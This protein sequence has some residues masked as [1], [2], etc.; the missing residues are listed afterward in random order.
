MST[1]RR[2]L[3]CA[4]VALGAPAAGAGPALAHATLLRSSPSPRAHVAQSSRSVV[5]RFSEPVQIVNR[6]DVTIVDGRGVRVDS[7][8]PST[9]PG[10][11]AGV[12][13]PLRGP[14]VPSSYTVRYRVISADSHFSDAAFVFAVGGAR[15][16]EPILAGAG[17]LSDTS[18]A[19]VALRMG[20][21]VALGLLLGLLVFRAAVWGPAVAAARGLA[22]AERDAALRLGQ[23]AFWRAFWTLGV[24]AGIAETGILAAKSAVVFH[25]GLI[26]AALHPAAAFRLVAASRFGDLLGWRTAAL[27]VLAGV[28]FVAWSA[29]SPERPSAGRRGMFALMAVPAIAALTLL[30]GQ[31]HA[32]QAP[33]A[34]VSI[35]ADATHLAGAAIWIGGLPCLAAVLLAVPRALP[36]GGRILAS[37]VLRRFSRIALWSVAVVALTGLVRMAGE[38]SSVAQ[39]W[40][41]AYGRDLV[42]KASL[43]L[44]VVV[45]ARRN[46]RFV[47][48][49]AG[50]LQP[51][52]ARLQGVA[53]SVQ[54]ELAIA[55][56][57]VAVAAVL[58]AELPG[59]A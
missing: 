52:A 26:A 49:L 8:A 18:P 37:E 11:P 1:V 5:L 51:T 59:R 10:D 4:L 34:P 43:L 47:A 57:I 25:T 35:A 48:A 33:V 39:L 54:I 6:S 22:P 19:A 45:L 14:L 30:A 42:L 32:S 3:V 38:L 58:V 55:M 12:V 27:A 29:E 13:V 46:R 23:R 40:S 16:R 20:E 31:G 28:A 15:L 2:A 53:R 24:L 7:G 17:G 9:A 21:L 41:T 44:P 56:G 50:G 36:G